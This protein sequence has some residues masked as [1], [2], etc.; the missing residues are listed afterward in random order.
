MFLAR[1]WFSV[2]FS[3]AN[4]ASNFLSLQQ[5]LFNNSLAIKMSFLELS[6]K[7]TN[8]TFTSFKM[9]FILQVNQELEIPPTRVLQFE[10]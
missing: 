3:S 5:L 7:K 2:S 1:G 6:K 10:G 9:I 8:L 4:S